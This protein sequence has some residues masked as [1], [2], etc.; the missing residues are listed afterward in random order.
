LTRLHRLLPGTALMLGVSAFMMIEKNVVSEPSSSSELVATYV[1]H[2]ISLDASHPA[3]EWKQALPIAFSSDWQGENPDSSRETRVRVLWSER[4][5][6]LRFECRYRELHLFPDSEPN[7]RRDHL[8]DRDVAEAFLQPDP[9]RER[10]YREFEV[11]PNG[12]WIALDIFPG[13]RADLE[14]GLERSVFLDEKSLTW[15]AELGI[16]L[17]LL[18]ARFDASA[19]WRANFYRI[20]G[21][22]EPRSYLAWQP[23]HTPQPNFHV[24]RAFG[25]LRF[26]SSAGA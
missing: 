11:S 22:Q 12:M 18:T 9:S 4:T 6:F 13:G 19:M 2:E 5:L 16:P 25:W 3:A 8:W 17:R 21:Q 15:S 23:T 26:A 10:F 1:S 24:P 14:S 7:G 20:E